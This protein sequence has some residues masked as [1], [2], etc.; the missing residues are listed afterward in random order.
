MIIRGSLPAH[1]VQRI[2][3]QLFSHHNRSWVVGTLAS[4]S[5]RRRFKSRP[6]HRLSWLRISVVFLSP[7]CISRDGSLNYIANASFHIL[8]KLS[9]FST[10]QSVFWDVATLRICF[11]SPSS[12][13]WLILMEAAS[14]SETLV[15][16]H[17][18]TRRNNWCLQSCC[19]ENLISQSASFFFMSTVIC[20]S[21]YRFIF[22]S[23]Q[24][25]RKCRT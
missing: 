19:R 18:T 10:V 14:I 21:I 7:L 20:V 15:T 11:L 5:G 12:W 25:K 16:F 22:T 6:G 13:R 4:N 23:I 9:I 1:T 8:S 3:L 2:C 17:Q 24:H